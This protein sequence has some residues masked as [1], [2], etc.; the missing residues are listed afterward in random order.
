[1]DNQGTYVPRRRYRLNG[2]KLAAT[3]MMLAFITAVVAIAIMAL[4]HASDVEVAS[5]GENLQP[6][7]SNTLSVVTITQAPEQPTAA[8]AA[9]TPNTPGVGGKG[10][11]ANRVIVLDA[12]HG[13]FDPGAIGVSGAYEDDIN[14]AVAQ[15]LKDELE[16]KGAQVVMTRDDEDALATE[17]DADMAE[18][19]RIIEQSNSDIV[20]SIHMNNFKEDPSVSGPLVLFMPGSDKGKTLAEYVQACLNTALDSAGSARSENLFI[21]KSGNQPCVLV[22]CGYLSNEDEEESLRQPDY[23]RKLAKAICDGAV[24]FLLEQ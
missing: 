10:V 22:E 4:K 19:R 20:I 13:G 12:G 24:T 23:Q 1:M 14:L 15:Y 5:V 21:L 16:D 6:T 7:Q 11:L 3:L 2:K 8:N 17:K 9:A 18:R